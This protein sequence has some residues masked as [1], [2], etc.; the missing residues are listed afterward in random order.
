MILA[1]GKLYDNSAQEQILS[2]LAAEINLTRSEKELPLEA[3]IAALDKLGCMAENGVFDAR[4]AKLGL[5]DLTATVH[6]AACLLRRESL[7]CKL[8]NELGEAPFLPHSTAPPAGQTALTTQ[9]LPLGTLFHIAAGN[10]DG[11]PA[12]SVAEGLLTGNINLLKL[13]QADQGISIEILQ[14]LIALEPRISDFLYVFDTPSSDLAAM[15]RLAE[16]ADGIIVWGGDAAVTAVRH[17]APVG[18]KLIEW[19]HKLGFAYISG[20]PPTAELAELAE[21]ILFTKQLLCSSCQ[22]IFLDSDAMDTV[23]AFCRRFLPLMEEAALRHPAG[24]ISTA[25]EITL[26]RYHARLERAMGGGAADNLVYQGKYCCLTACQDSS[27]A[28]SDLFGSCLVK[29]LPRRSLFTQL[30]QHK[31]YLQTAGLIC[32]EAERPALANLLARAGVTRVM[33]AGHMSATFCGEA[34]DGEY[35][36]RRYLRAVDIE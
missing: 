14:Q 27:L 15:Q 26:R 10:L 17:L 35:A 32:P 6:E 30:R 13:P 9:L 2:G 16:L 25:A 12:V 3:V 29:R 8:R 34:H 28:L 11:L 23:H 4:L 7:L 19:G 33:R 18:A 20:D 31:G 1:K 5:A 22:T 36:L 24:D 21:H